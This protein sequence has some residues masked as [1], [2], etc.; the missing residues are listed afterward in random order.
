MPLKP[1]VAA[2]PAMLMLAG[3]AGVAAAAHRRRQVPG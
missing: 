2:L 3:L 1:W